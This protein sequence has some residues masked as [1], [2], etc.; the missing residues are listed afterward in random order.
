MDTL[1]GA[2]I[3]EMT[4]RVRDK[5][6]DVFIATETELP[7]GGAPHIPGYSTMVPTVSVSK[8]VRN[9]LYINKCLH[10]EQIPTPCDIPIIA[11][12]VGSEVIIGLY[13]EFSQISATETTRGN[14]FE[15]EEFDRI[16]SFIR[17]V[18]EQHKIVHIAGDINLDPS[19]AGDE[20][21]Y[22]KALL[23]RWNNLMTELGM[24]WAE[25]GPTYK[26][27]GSRHGQH[28]LSTIDLIYSRG[29]DMTATVLSDG[30]GDHWPIFA[31]VRG[32]TK[33]EIPKRETRVD[34]N[35]KSLDTTVLNSF[36]FDYDWNP[37]MTA[38][39]SETAVTLLNVALK[40]AINTAVPEREYTTPNL[41]VRLKKDTLAAMRAR[42]LAKKNGALKYKALRNRALSLVRRDYVTLNVS[43]I[44]NGGPEEAWKVAS[45]I[46]GKEKTSAL[47]LPRECLSDQ[48]AADKC[49]DYFVEKVVNLRSKMS[50]Q[51]TNNQ[52]ASEGDSFRFHCVGIAT[53][54]KALLKLKTKLSYGLDGVPITVIKEAFEPLALPLVHLTNLV[55]KTGKWPTSWKEALVTPGL[56]TGKPSATLS[57]YRP[58]SNLCSI[59][60]LIERVLYDQMV[61]FLDEKG[62]LPKEQHGFRSGRSTDT[63]LATLFT[64]VALAQDKGNKVTMLAF[65][66]SSAFDTVSSEV[67]G[68]K[69]GWACES[70]K[71]LL[72]NYMS[73][74]TQK[75]KW[76]SFTSKVLKI[77]YGVPQGSILAPLL[78][79][80]LTGDLPESIIARVNTKSTAGATLYA[81]DT[82]AYISSKSWEENETAERALTEGLEDFS[83]TN[84]L[85]LNTAKTQKLSLGN[86]SS[87]A[88]NILG[89]TIDRSGGFA[90]HHENIHNDLRRRL[91]MVRNLA[92]QMPRGKLLSEIG[93][94]LII[95]R[96]QC[97][98]FVTR[99]A[100]IGAKA[101]TT[102][103][104]S[105]AGTT[106]VLLNDLS[107]VLLGVTRADRL[108]TEDLT[109]RA[110]VPTLNQIV[111]R[112]S[113]LNAWRA[114]HDGALKEV[115]VPFD[116]RTRGAANNLRRPVSQRS[117]SS[118]NM[119]LTW[120]ASSK[121]REAKSL[122]EARK[123]ARR[124]GEFARHM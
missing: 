26:S 28:K 32:G 109:D 31:K 43:R 104:S 66:F 103:K 79:I 59:S 99:P 41:G 89:V 9:V 105:A 4:S 112:Q 96:L 61:S 82:S 11:A 75:V 17:S 110:E 62:I 50:R 71:A 55:I 118:C 14:A 30:T 72:L 106:Q 2:K 74:R 57:S 95:G 5:S 58:I 15:T 48:E 68:S 51:C 108:K 20:E 97:N 25:T 27:Y 78:F 34:R 124:L 116:D 69:L 39:E 6:P 122:G 24:I 70:A 56:K 83:R 33:H 73:D 53:L 47:P 81:D 119:A 107:R 91:G 80:I 123:E 22:K 98:A 23:K 111:V 36:L 77:R 65:D 60:K 46:R 86:T 101:S 113:A 44:K 21:Y 18:A 85:A 63:A 88:I 93:R 100:R 67:M 114:V 117:I 87:E 1:R 10:G 35:W 37:L 84:E 120:N 3:L 76:N 92:C 40:E 19:R 29:R 8:I 102:R 94:S 90:T 38:T 115:L 7:V 52:R 49:N 16:E 64:N 54:R 121:L 45:Q 12:K 13:R 42:D